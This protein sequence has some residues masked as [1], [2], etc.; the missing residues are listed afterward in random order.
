MDDNIFER[1]NQ[2]SK[3][4]RKIQ[5]N[6]WFRKT[7]SDSELRNSIKLSFCKRPFAKYLS[8]Q[9]RIRVS[10]CSLQ[11]SLKTLNLNKLRVIEKG[12]VYLKTESLCMFDSINWSSILNKMN[13]I[14]INK[15]NIEYAKNNCCKYFDKF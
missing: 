1:Q 14:N 7:S 2:N 6:S 4:N 12:D 15:Q 5:R 13:R 9:W 8:N 11:K 3:F 10:Y